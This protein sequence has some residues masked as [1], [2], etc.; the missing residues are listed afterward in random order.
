M[1]EFTEAIDVFFNGRP[2][3]VTVV[4]QLRHE[5]EKLKVALAE[6]V[7]LQSHYAGLLNIWDGGK[8]M[9]FKTAREWLE[10]LEKI[11]GV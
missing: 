8:R 5:N 3:K 11:K 6:S 1:S 10:R 7:K 4:D 9:T 2:A